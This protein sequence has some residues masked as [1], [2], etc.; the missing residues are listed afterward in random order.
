M[1]DD[2]SASPATAHATA[3]PGHGIRRTRTVDETA[4]LRRRPSFKPPSTRS[5]FTDAQRRDSTFSDFSCNNDQGNAD[6]LWNLGKMATNPP[7]PTMAATLPLVLAL[8]PAVGGLFFEGGSAFFT[9]VILLGLAAIFLRWSVTQPWNWYHA[10][11]QV[12][13]ARE[14]AMSTPVFETDSDLELSTVA[15]ATTAL[16]EVPE[17]DEKGHGHEADY[18]ES[19]KGATYQEWEIERDAAVKS[20]R[21]HEKF[22]LGWCFAFPLLAAYLLHNIR[23][24]L[25]PRSEGLVSDYNLH[26]FV[27]AAE[28]RPISHFIR[29]LQ[30]STLHKQ[31]IVA[32]N[33][34]EQQDTRDQQFQQLHERIDGVETRLAAGENMSMESSRHEQQATRNVENLVMH[35]YRERV[36]PEV[37]SV[38]RAMRRYEKKLSN[39]IDQID[40][41]LEYLDQRSNDAIALAA[42]AARQKTSQ[43]NLIAWLFEQTAAIILLPIQTA[44]AI[45]TFPFRTVSLLLGRTSRST[46]EKHHKKGHY[47]G[48]LFFFFWCL[49]AGLMV[50]IMI[51]EVT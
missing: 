39:I 13:V 17:A 30:S 16:E 29:L 4:H 7:E 42:I 38:T 14:M 46:A 6:G 31:R 33:P 32:T 3:P 15:S 25:S 22:A 18:R 36:Q 2:R 9:D 28:I 43:V 34:Y 47:A 27:I 24:Q 8:L 21:W 10:A 37:E 40:I 48:R 19:P 5:S 45:F 20:L 44:I 12:R 11:Q 26:I 35:N 1:A 51:K 41:R 50:T 23:G 49:K